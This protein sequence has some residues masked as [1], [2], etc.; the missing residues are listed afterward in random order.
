[1]KSNRISILTIILLGAT[2]AFAQ[3]NNL[4]QEV[5][6]IK[7]YEPVIND[8]YKISSLPKI[9]DTLNVTP[10]FDYDDGVTPEMYKTKY[11]P[12]QMKP[13]KLVAEPLPKLYNVYVKGGFGMYTTPLLNIY[14]GSQRSEKWLWN[15]NMN[16]TSS[17][18]KVKNEDDKRVYAGLSKFDINGS[19]HRYFKNDMAASI[20][21]GYG[22]RGNYYYG[23][24]TELNLPDSL[25]PLKRKDI[26]KQSVNYYNI[27]ATVY[28]TNLDSAEI[29]YKVSLGYNGLKTKDSKSENNIH[30]DGY[31]SY[32]L[33]KEFLGVKCVID[34]YKT[35]GLANDVNS[36]VVNFNPW[37]GA[38]GRK[39]RVKVGVNTF[40]DQR[41]QKYMFFPDISMQYNII[42]YF[43][44]P[45]VEL[46]G[47]YK[48][49]DYKDMYFENQFVKSD[50]RINPTKTR[51]NLALG[52]RGNI[53]SR[54]AFNIKAEYA[55]IDNQYF[56]VNDTSTLLH[57][58]F[59]VVYDDIMR[60]HI[61][62]E[63]SYKTSEKFKIGLKGHYYIYDMST[64]LEAWHLPTYNISLDAS[65]NL[66]NKIIAT[67][68]VYAVSRRQAC[69][70]QV[71][72]PGKVLPVAKELDGVI[73]IN[74]G[75]E[76][77]ITKR[78]SGFLDLNN[79]TGSRYYQWNQYANQRFNFM[80]GLTYA[81]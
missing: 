29:D 11:K 69:L 12:K 31:I 53:S 37:V 14:T 61:L 21:A 28:S 50:L 18:A 57:E 35:Q 64:E 54:I 13:A 22:N 49:H 5:K 39:W 10:T 70:Y 23:Y 34:N 56:F 41:N 20:S 81:F 3:N 9:V 59:F 46:N 80:L 73:D 63:I 19:V 42:D 62:G 45:Y 36:A 33:D 60:T 67:A 79:L 16:Y 65:Y 26:E 51:I 71:D 74:L 66:S 52:F 6:V 44:L 25:I 15:A 72:G 17:S 76:Y 4:N 1:M 7:A 47:N 38:Y 43:L 78:F 8:A 40:Y 55:K 68:N 2:T 48:V 27:G 77:R 30:F 32:L 75:V 24:A 58:K